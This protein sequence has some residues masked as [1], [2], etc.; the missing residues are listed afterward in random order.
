MRIMVIDGEAVILLGKEMWIPKS[1][2]TAVNERTN[3]IQ[4]SDWITRMKIEEM[5]G[6]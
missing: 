3:E 4:I 5:G 1:Q 6:E 2:I